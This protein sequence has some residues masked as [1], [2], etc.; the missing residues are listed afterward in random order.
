MPIKLT[1]LN[2]R[3]PPLKVAAPV[4]VKLIVDV[5]A[6]KVRFVGVVKRIGDEDESVNVL[7]P[8]LMARTFELDE[9]SMFAVIFCPFVVNVPLVTVRVNAPRL[10]GS[11][12]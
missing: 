7:A 4:E 1:S 3:P 9:E 12:S 10:S 8:R 6:L 5:P 11:I 2:E